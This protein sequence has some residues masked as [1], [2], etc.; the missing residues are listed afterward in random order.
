MEQ[1]KKLKMLRIHD[2]DDVTSVGGKSDIIIDVED[3]LPW[4]HSLPEVMEDPTEEELAG[5]AEKKTVMVRKDA[6]LVCSA[7]NGTLGRYQACGFRQS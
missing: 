7:S 3:G 5:A 6:S 4:C 2:D 1:R